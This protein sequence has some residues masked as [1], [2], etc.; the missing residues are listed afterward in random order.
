MLK[1]QR[2]ITY[3]DAFDKYFALGSNLKQRDSKSVRKIVSGLIKLCHPDGLFTKEEI[4]EYL[5]LAMEMRRRVKE[6]LKR[7]GGMEFW[8]TNF[9]YIDKETQEEIFVGLPEERGSHLIESNPLSPGVC[10][11]STSNGTVNSLVRIEVV[12]LKG[13]GKVNVTGTNSQEVKE[14]IK[15]TYNYIRANEKTILNE[16][17]SLSGYDLNIQIRSL[18]GAYISGGIGSAVYVAILSAIYKKNLK[19]GLAVLGNISVGGSVESASFF[20]DKVSL[21]SENGAKTVLV[22]MEN[23]NEMTSLPLGV[24]GK[25]DTPFYGNSQMLLQ[26]AVMGE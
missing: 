26:K 22:P 18:L 23:L 25:T 8:D 19:A 2:K 10:Y 16:Q 5:V 7:I 11:T 17:H 13:S 12:A 3:Y 4:R 14:N 21:L 1:S 24:L 9:S 20:A 15:N 6:Q